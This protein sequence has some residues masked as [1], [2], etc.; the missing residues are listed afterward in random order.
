M[1]QYWILLST[2]FVISC[3]PSG[4]TATA[5]AKKGASATSSCVDCEATVV[6]PLDTLEIGLTHGTGDATIEA[7]VGEQIVLNI[8]SALPPEGVEGALYILEGT[9]SDC[10]VAG[11][12][13]ETPVTLFP[14]VEGESFLNA[15]TST[16]YPGAFVA[17]VKL[18]LG[19]FF[20]FMT[21]PSQIILR[22]NIKLS[23]GYVARPCGFYMNDDGKV[24]FANDCK[25]C[26]GVTADP[27]GDGVNEDLWY[28]DSAA[29]TD[30]G[31]C[32][33]ASSPCKTIQYAVDNLDGPSVGAED[34]IC[35]AGTFN[36]SVT[37]SQSGQTGF[38]SRDGF[39]FPKNPFM[40]VGWDK[41]GDGQ[42][43]PYDTDDIALFDS[44]D[45]KNEVFDGQTFSHIEIAH[46]SVANY[47]GVASTWLYYFPQTS[48]ARSHLYFH[49]IE[50]R[51]MDEG[52]STGA[53]LIF[54]ESDLTN[55]LSY[56]AME[57][58]D[59][60]EIGASLL[61][62]SMNIPDVVHH[63]RI[64]NV[65]L[66]VHG[67]SNTTWHTVMHASG[68]SDLDIFANNFDGG[69]D[70]WTPS[71]L[72]L[73]NLGNCSKRV[74]LRD[75]NIIDFGQPLNSYLDGLC[76]SAPMDDI[77]VLRNFMTLKNH[78]SVIDGL[79]MGWRGG[80]PSDTV[81]AVAD[82][83]IIGNYII[84]TSTSAHLY[85]IASS[86]GND[87]GVNPGVVKIVGNTLVGFGLGVN[88]PSVNGQQ[89]YIVSHN[90]FAGTTGYAIDFNY[91]PTN[92]IGQSNAV[93]TAMSLRWNGSTEADLTAFSSAVQASS[94]SE[95]GSFQCNTTFANAAA[96]NYHL[97]TNDTCA[98][99]KGG[100]LTPYFAFD[101]DRDDVHFTSS[102][103]GADQ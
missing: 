15:D 2:L 98:K 83:N 42:Y 29:G 64:N 7:E 28:V 14:L 65:S 85:A 78:T 45:S 52:N 66:T 20:K 54:V 26:D 34:I 11:I 101:Y 81:N 60:E 63:M 19:S 32:G 90:I 53:G 17:C 56:V 91:A 51:N 36:E 87:S 103:I 22:Q 31:A 61:H 89:N 68:V 38:K 67:Q 100:D 35:I 50:F 49:D 18:T 58:V 13:S 74:Y 80:G 21:L 30:G 27:D 73:L 72:V 33:T 3:T 84:K 4:R 23:K 40:I 93:G 48:P 95:T 79:T 37:L 88:N 86:I 71:R 96:G 47:S 75:N 10:T 12:A 9:A 92:Y 24:G 8:I 77:Y 5:D 46:I 43:P 39:Q 57:N 62:I 69:Y 70:A 76:P 99:A 94:G 16:L 1:I 41:D 6:D 102:N 55:S 44:G 97:A 82:M 59:A 25:I